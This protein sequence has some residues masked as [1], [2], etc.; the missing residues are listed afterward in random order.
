MFVRTGRPYSVGG[1]DESLPEGDISKLR[2]E[3]HTYESGLTFQ[4]AEK[5][6]LSEETACAKA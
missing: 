2:A 4:T 6:L 1:L 3:T 5:V